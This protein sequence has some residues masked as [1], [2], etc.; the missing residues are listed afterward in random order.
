MLIVLL[1]VAV[2]V[3]GWFLYSF[4]EEK[5]RKAGLR[6]SVSNRLGISVDMQAP[7]RS[8]KEIE[9]LVFEESKHLYNQRIGEIPDF[10]KSAEK[11]KICKRLSI[12]LSM[13]KNPKYTITQLNNMANRIVKDKTALSL[14]NNMASFQEEKTKQ[15]LATEMKIKLPVQA[16]S[17]K[18]KAIRSEIIKKANKKV[19][20]KYPSRKLATATMAIV[21]KYRSYSE[22][23][24]VTVLDKNGVKVSGLYRGKDGNKVVI[25]YRKILVSDIIT[26][27]K[28]KF[29]KVLS[30][31][32]AAMTIRKLKGEFYKRRKLFV[33]N[34]NKKHSAETYRKY[35]YC[36]QKAKWLPVYSILKQKV[37]YARS[38]FNKQQ[39]LRNK[40]II[41]QA[42]KNF[43][44][45]LFFRKHGYIKIKGRWYSE[46]VAVEMNLKNIRKIYD[47]NRNKQ[48]RKL[49]QDIRKKTE[50]KVYKANN[51]IYLNKKWQ[52]AVNVIEQEINKA[53][54]QAY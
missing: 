54:V 31:N 53:D 6:K 48:E 30:A 35:G 23:E 37:D 11:S 26:S 24:R 15:K 16:P 12:P 17:K 1:V 44:R 2:S 4:F 45:D 14:K 36:K 5:T 39:K 8:L 43:N 52:P 25:G 51:Y 7:E 22:G 27:E 3:G 29:D 47:T 40:Q 33:K 38:E 19:V 42:K 18:L 21:K 34:Y 41:N 28:I 20:E 32:K 46:N 49:K 13:K 9:K 50:Q 10:D